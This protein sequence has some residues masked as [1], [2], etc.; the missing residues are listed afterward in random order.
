MRLKLKK[1]L[2]F[3]PVTEV[4]TPAGFDDAVATAVLASDLMSDVLASDAE[5]PL[6]LTS[7]ATEQAIRSADMVGAVAVLIANGKRIS[8]EMTTLAEEHEIALLRTP[9][10]KYEACLEIGKLLER[11]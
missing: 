6:L 10:A 5:M 2:E 4:V 1:L 11:E 8:K 3:L 7:L 9:L